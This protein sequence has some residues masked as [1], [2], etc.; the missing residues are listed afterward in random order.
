[1]DTPIIGPDDVTLVGAVTRD[2]AKLFRDIGRRA[3]PLPDG[4]H[5][6]RFRFGEDSRGQL[7]VWIVLVAE[8]DLKPSKTKIDNI[9]RFFGKLQDEILMS[10]TDRW[11]YTEVVT[12]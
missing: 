7:A 6:L 5:E 10:D 3:G 11:P 9:R 2:E 4:A 1:M 8:D 12:I